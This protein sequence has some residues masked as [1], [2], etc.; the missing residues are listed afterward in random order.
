MNDPIVK[1]TFDRSLVHARLSAA[2]ASPEFPDFLHHRATEDIVDRLNLILRD[3]ETAVVIA[4][5]PDDLTPRLKATGR[6]KHLVAA[7][8]T[9][10]HAADIV[11]NDEILPFADNSVDCIISLLNLHHVNDLPGALIQIARALRPDG[12]FMAA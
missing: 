3:F 7:R 8:T 5:K 9:G 12:L 4:D 11:C 10:H 6:F 1:P 2:M